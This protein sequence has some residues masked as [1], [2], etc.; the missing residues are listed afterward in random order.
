MISLFVIMGKVLAYSFSQGALAKED[1]SLQAFLFDRS[2]E[3]FGESVLVRRTGWKLHRLDSR[4]S[5]NDEVLSSVERIAV[6]DQIA[7]AP[8]G[9]FFGV[10]DVAPNLFH[11]ESVGGLGDPPKLNASGREL[12]KEENHEALET[13]QR[14]DLHGEEICGGNL[15]KVSREKFFPSRLSLSVRSGFNAVTLG[16]CW[17]W[18]EREI[19]AEIC[20]SSDNAVVAPSS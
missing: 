12:D 6:V 4:F 15:I 1:H 3:S 14:P 8:Q 10:R 17:Q 2:D 13:L 16:G 5:K 11:P 20:K 18:Y 9:S 7:V 19:V